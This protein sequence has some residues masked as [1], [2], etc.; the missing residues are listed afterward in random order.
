MGREKEAARAGR[1][2][3]G[4][5]ERGGGPSPQAS[6]SSYRPWMHASREPVNP[7]GRRSQPEGRKAEERGEPK[8]GRRNDDERHG[9]GAATKSG[10]GMSRWRSHRKRR[11]AEGTG[12]GETGFRAMLKRRA[13]ALNLYGSCLCE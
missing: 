11:E 1:L 12:G 7:W 13:S 6:T 2:R 4:G 5:G 9:K 10:G 8:K 3:R